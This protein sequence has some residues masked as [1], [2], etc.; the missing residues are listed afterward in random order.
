MVLSL[1]LR[2]GLLRLALVWWCLSTPA[3][4]WV[5]I[6]PSG[7]VTIRDHTEVSSPLCLWLPLSAGAAAAGALEHCSDVGCA[8]LSR[9]IGYWDS[10]ESSKDLRVT[11]SEYVRGNVTLTNGACSRWI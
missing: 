9:Q 8:G 11:G 4:A 10:T 1:M 6:S 3:S 7:D 2:P 5:G